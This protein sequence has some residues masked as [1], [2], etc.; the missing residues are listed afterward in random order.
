MTY[1]L[2]L[3]EKPTAAKA[4]AE[5]LSDDKPKKVGDKAAWYEFTKDGKDFVT[6]PAVGHLFTLKQA[7][8]GWAY[9]V[10]DVEW[11]P[12]FKANKFAS[13]SEPY[14]RN[15]EQLAKD[16]G[17]VIVATDYDD[18][19][20]VIGFNI[21]RFL[22]GRKD[23]SRM[24]FSTM[25]K[26]ELLDSYAHPT[27][28]NKNL[29]E[30]GLA[31]HYLDFYWGISLTRA[32]TLAVKSAAKRF[33]IVSTGRVQGPVL[34]VLAKHEKKI[35]AFKPDPFWELEL[36]V[37]IGKQLLTAEHG[38]KIWDRKEAD[39]LSKKA[40]T[41]TV[42]VKNITKKIMTQAP[43]KPYNTTSMLAD[44]YRYFGYSPQQGLSIAESLY[45]A[46][47][48][49]YPRTSSEK[50][51]KDINYKKIITALGKQKNYE[52]EAKQLLAGELKPEEGSKTDAAH[53][54][55]YPTG[56]YK[57]MGDKQQRVYDLVTRRFL[58]V[59]GQPAKRESNK[60]ILDAKGVEFSL[61]GKKT[62]EAGW[63]SLYGKY[64]QREEIILPDIKI[65]D[66]FPVKKF[67][68]L[69]KE[70][71]PPARF[72][73]GSVLKEMETRGLGTKCLTGDCKIITPDSCDV[74]LSDLWEKSTPLGCEDDVEIRKL[75]TPTTIS[76]N[77]LDSG[78]EF[79][80]PNLISRRR[81]KE[82]EKVLSIKTKGGELKATAE[83]PIYLYKDDSVVL[84]EASKVREGDKLVSVI[85]RNKYGK[86]LADKDWFTGR[87][88]KVQ[89]GMFVHR[90]AQRNSL[91]IELEKLP[92]K[93]SSDLAW[94]LGYFYGDGSYNSPEYNGSHQLYFTTT[95]KKALNLLKARIK[96]VF[97]VEPKA[98]LVK[99]DRQY[100]V[101]CNSAIAAL[102][103][104]LFPSINK[105]QRFDIPK[106][107]AGDFLRGFFDAD[108][109][110][111][112]RNIG[113]V[114]INGKEAV[115]HGVP[116]VKITL[117]NKGLIL[118]ISEL[119]GE[120]GL[121]VKV[122]EGKAKLKEKYFKCFTILI[123]GR[124]RVDRFAWKI[125]FDV[126]HKKFTL[127]KGL[128]SDSLQYN[129]LKT[130]YSI[131][132]ALH[133][134][135]LDAP[136]LKAMLNC[137]A[138]DVSTTL[139][140]LVKMKIIKRKRLSPYSIPPN[141]V[142]Y[143]LDDKDYHFH[144]LKSV[145]RHI[146]GEFYA[147]EIQNIEDVT[148][149][150]EFVYDISVSSESPNFITNG[151]VLVHNSTRAQILQILYNRGYLLGKSIEVTELGEQLS[152]I[153]EKNVPD[154]ISDKLTR[155]FEE[156][157]ESIQVQKATKEQVLDEAKKRIEKICNDF[158]KKEKK[159]G[160]ELTNAVIATQ[161]KQSK[162]GTCLKCSGTL[163]V[164]KN[165]RT[166]KRFVGC[167]GYP[168]GCRVGFPL[169]REGI[170][171]STEKSCETCKQPIIQVQRPASRPFRMCLDPTCATKKDWLDKNRLKAAQIASRKSSKEA[172]QLK[173]ECGKMFKTKRALTL[174]QKTHTKVN[175][176][177]T[178]AK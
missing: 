138:Y 121:K 95:E 47:M 106:E 177:K 94:V 15:I 16:A 136:A 70:T 154:V 153:L 21:L 141:R 105:K 142:I 148:N 137:S 84:T 134:E 108:G 115:G 58:A 41:K 178:K 176:T 12:S 17:D 126:D 147:A 33:R 89:N 125:G 129:I 175:K 97:G 159:I 35:K 96:R 79:T 71:Q 34:H 20:E 28:L 173:C 52:K 14:F 22:L 85:S 7:S 69:S 74:S 157:T 120:L 160:E 117:A 26:E 37:Q 59:F 57:K 98:Y 5:A 78:I 169:P 25:T 91:G 54:A 92:I 31:R 53:P 152:D 13:F 23:A 130:S 151:G 56:V 150:D 38:K 113:K 83:H 49:S 48:I 67:D 63:T 161:D 81:L 55:V 131:I 73:Q 110:V 27:K 60:I 45:Q 10:F 158:R 93:W 77:E 168:K 114:K 145:Y 32:L 143:E 116:R 42:T 171:T 167:S 1:T 9:P 109:N 80:K 124:E 76:L 103:S 11:V 156:M 123:G 87:K 122:K 135:N 19:G 36:Q 65:G 39:L 174:H 133:K 2:I 101:Q 104:D 102:L 82:K 119:L 50:L 146:G 61:N 4:I 43:P 88:F 128:L 62:T 144:A 165:W 51:P 6:V 132:L 75:N 66:T 164:H 40:N 112:L 100:K 44:I 162:L 46:G 118:W 107:F 86:I 166:G 18:E 111:H 64:A 172:E 140:R 29:I 68:L 90:F 3:T 163:K 155:H 24:K 127:Y 30:S 72:S 170:I 8:K 149:P 139:K 99:N